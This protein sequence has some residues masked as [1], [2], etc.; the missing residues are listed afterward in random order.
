VLATLVTMGLCGLWHGAGWTFIAWGLWHGV[1]LILCR[2][3]QQIGRPLPAFAGWAITML[4]VLAGWVVF[5][6]S[7][8]HAAG[9]V[10]ASLAGVNGFGGAIAEAKLIAVAALA[11]ALIP[12]AHEIKER[13]LRPSPALALVT[14]LLAAFCVFEVGRGAPVNF[15]YFQF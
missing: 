14:A 13:L 8:F 6:A 5:R 7:G 1:G 11:S 2:G 12:S 9:A 15:I 3:W 10:L 4:F